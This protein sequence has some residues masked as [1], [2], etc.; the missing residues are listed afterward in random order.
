MYYCRVTYVITSYSIHY[1]KLYDKN[2]YSGIVKDTEGNAL[3]DVEVFVKE[4]GLLTLTNDDGGFT[5][6]QPNVPV[7]IV[8]GKEG[9]MYEQFV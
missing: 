7:T 3:S 8:F 1:T 2:K 9:Y 5:V 6:E 4:T